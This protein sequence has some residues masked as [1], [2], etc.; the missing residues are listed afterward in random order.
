MS[1]PLKETAESPQF[2]SVPVDNDS[3]S[4]SELEELEDGPSAAD[5][6]HRGFYLQEPQS[7]LSTLVRY[8]WLIGILALSL[9]AGCLL[10]LLSSASPP[11][12][13]EDLGGATSGREINLFRTRSAGSA[14][15]VAAVLAAAAA[16]LP[17]HLAAHRRPHRSRPRLPRL[18]CRDDVAHGGD[19]LHL[20]LPHRGRGRARPA[21]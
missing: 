20:R 7:L 6:H 10:F 4:D 19:D 14:A 21:E 1:E 17:L 11:L 15:R 16:V 13:L 8:R 2:T 9:L 18:L 3:L 5:P 12:T